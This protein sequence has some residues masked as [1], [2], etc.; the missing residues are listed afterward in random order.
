[1]KIRNI[2]HK[3][4]KNLYIQGDPKGLPANAVPKLNN[5][6]AFLQDM[7]EIKELE[8]FPLWKVH[9]LKGDRKGTMS[10]SVTKNW[11]LTFI[12]NT[13]ENEINDLNFEDYH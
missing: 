3:G 13:K 6:L 5:M 8:M 7:Q 1:M 4:L 11:R 2:L 9:K 10:L 12:H